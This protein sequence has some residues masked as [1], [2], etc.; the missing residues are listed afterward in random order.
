MHILLSIRYPVASTQRL[1]LRLALPKTNAPDKQIHTAAQYLRAFAVWSVHLRDGKH[2]TPAQILLKHQLEG[3]HATFRFPQENIDTLETRIPSTDLYAVV[4]FGGVGY[5]VQLANS[6]GAF[7]IE[8]ITAK[9]LEVKAL[10]IVRTRHRA[11]TYALTLTRMLHQ[12][13]EWLHIHGE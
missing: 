7:T 1:S 13:L 9:L 6:G 2:Q 5:K 4:W 3:L 10:N 8:F 11:N 12:F